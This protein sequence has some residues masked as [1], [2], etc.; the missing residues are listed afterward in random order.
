M[1]TAQP[2]M[3]AFEADLAAVQQTF[4]TSGVACVSR[5]VLLTSYRLNLLAMGVLLRELQAAGVQNAQAAV[6]ALLRDADG[7]SAELGE[8]TVANLQ[9]NVESVVRPYFDFLAASSVTQEMLAEITG[10]QLPAPAQETTEPCPDSS[11]ELPQSSETTGE[12]SS[13]QR[14][15]IRGLLKTPSNKKKAGSPGKRRKRKN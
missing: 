4:E 9:I 11:L 15:T 6:R 13:S 8:F 2:D 3:A 14:A 1:S 12:L 7:M 10:E 5:A